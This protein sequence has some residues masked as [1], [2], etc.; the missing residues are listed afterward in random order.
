MFERIRNALNLTPNQRQNLTTLSLMGG[1]MAMTVCVGAL[2]Y[3]LRYSWPPEIL[4]DLAPAILDDIS[5]IAFGC[6]FLVGVMVIA[7]ASIAVGGRFRGRLGPAEVEAGA[8]DKGG[9]VVAPA[10]T[11]D[12]AGR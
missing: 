7:Q 12:P 10:E 5:W 1:A 9:E 6:L 8:D 3:I 2:I 11:D 4:K